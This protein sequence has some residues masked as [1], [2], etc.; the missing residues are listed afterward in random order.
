MVGN[1]VASSIDYVVTEAK[2]PQLQVGGVNRTYEGATGVGWNSGVS[3][4]AMVGFGGGM[5][6]LLTK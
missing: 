2:K 6:D 1:V 3:G 4:A 5:M